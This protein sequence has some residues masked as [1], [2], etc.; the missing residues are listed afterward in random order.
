MRFDIRYTTRF[1][2]GGPVTESQNDLR[3][4]PASNDRQQVLHYRV[5]TS[6]AARIAHHTDYWGTRVDSFGVRAPHDSLEVVAEATVETSRQPMVTV[7][8]SMA[9]LD[10]PTYRDEHVEYLRRS[11]HVAWG[12]EVVAAARKQADLVG[13]DVV[14]TV[15]ALHRFV[16]T[17]IEYVPG[18]TYVGVP[19]GEVL[20]Q[21]QGVCQDYAHLLIA[22]CRSLGIAARYVSGYL[23]ATDERQ[24]DQP[25]EDVVQVQTHAWV[26]MAVPGAEGWW[27]LDPTNR[28][29]VGVR[30][31]KIG[32][33]RD[34]DDVAP[35]RGTYTGGAE[36]GL[37]VDITIRRL[38]A[39]QQ[40]QQ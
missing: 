37:D 28:K 8:P 34:Y 15:L 40:Q 30:H 17:T 3:A 20:A 13:D 38:V 26:E 11:P 7:A 31:V 14:S 9:A 33:G 24:G 6:P 16:G 27:A 2:Y 18:A 19:T 4:C 32:H 10:D 1:T 35:L 25:E 5:T 12:E 36:H 21:Q 23:F 29:E 22:M 39:A